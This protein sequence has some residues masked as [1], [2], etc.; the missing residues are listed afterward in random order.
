MEGACELTVASDDL[1]LRCVFR[2][3]QSS[4]ETW[5]R[6]VHERGVVGGGV[7]AEALTESCSPWFAAIKR[8]MRVGVGLTSAERVYSRV[9]RSSPRR[10]L[11]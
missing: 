8:N 4:I 6:R 10:I 5:G 7:G 11:Q 2:N 3:V 1:P 9:P